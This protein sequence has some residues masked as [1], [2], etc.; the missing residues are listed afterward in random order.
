MNQILREVLI[1]Y[2][3]CD[4]FFFVHGYLC[5]PTANMMSQCVKKCGISPTDKGQ[6]NLSILQ[7]EMIILEIALVMKHYAQFTFLLCTHCILRL[8]RN[9]F[10]A[11]M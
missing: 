3:G 1:T 7:F 2:Y 6:S 9:C 5:K 11:T 4:F 8:N 10:P